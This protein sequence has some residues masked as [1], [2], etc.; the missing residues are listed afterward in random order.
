MLS[1]P[2]PAS[3]LLSAILVTDDVRSTDHEL[4]ALASLSLRLRRPHEIGTVFL[5]FVGKETETQRHRMTFPKVIPLV[6]DKTGIRTRAFCPQV[7]PAL[8]AATLMQPLDLLPLTVSQYPALGPQPNP[9][10]KQDAL[11]GHE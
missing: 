11:N 10:L 6:G 2:A 3:E 5:H 4:G 1:L 9:P 7:S 8:N